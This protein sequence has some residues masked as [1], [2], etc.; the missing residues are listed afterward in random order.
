MIIDTTRQT[1]HT[2]FAYAELVIRIIEALGHRELNSLID[3]QRA[4]Q[5]AKYFSHPMHVP[6]DRPI[7]GALLELIGHLAD[8]ASVL[9][10]SNYTDDNIEDVISYLA[11][12]TINGDVVTL[13]PRRVL[14]V[15]TF[16]GGGYNSAYGCSKEEAIIDARRNLGPVAD[17][18]DMKTM[19]P[20]RTRKQVE[21]YFNHGSTFAAFLNS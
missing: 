9:P 6:N 8:S 2:R 13:H 1:T 4:A 16:V 7:T 19:R 12:A 10:A 3:A 18:I 14:W 11:T 21:D 5:Q 17:T 15:F 20:L